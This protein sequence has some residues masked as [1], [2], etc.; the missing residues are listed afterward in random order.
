[1][2]PIGFIRKQIRRLKEDFI[3]FRVGWNWRPTPNGME[4]AWSL[5]QISQFEGE[6]A[7]A[8]HQ[9]PKA[10]TE[11]PDRSSKEI[12]ITIRLPI[13]SDNPNPR[14][15]KVIVNQ[16]TTAGRLKAYLAGKFNKN[17]EN[18]QIIA[19]SDGE[20]SY[21]LK[22]DTKLKDFQDDKRRRLYFYPR[23]L[24]E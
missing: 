22:K 18:W 17:E 10:A 14:I 9:Q 3:L 6:K 24:D 13:S 15:Y 1:M 4:S 7:N 23:I 5:G 8:I 11:R 12:T 16:E 20:L 19:R 2:S 21:A